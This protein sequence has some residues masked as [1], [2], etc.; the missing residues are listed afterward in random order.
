MSMKRLGPLV[1]FALCLVGQGGAFAATYQVLPSNSTAQPGDDLDLSV[2]VR[3]EQGDN[4]V[5]L[6]Y[7]S[8]AI[9]LDIFGTAGAT[10]DD[11]GQVV[12]NTMLFDLEGFNAIGA[13]SGSRYVGISGLTSR[14]FAPTFGMHVGDIVDLFTFQI[15][16]PIDAQIGSEI[17]ILPSEGFL[18][19]L[20]AT[21]TFDPVSPQLFET[22][23]IVVVPEPSTF[24]L[25]GT[26]LVGSLLRSGFKTG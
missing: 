13:A 20:A 10:G 18:Q 1:A 25:L 23:R 16:I 2:S 6:G 8:F 3:T 4:V 11:I 19:N 22:T 14:V 12:L 5:G 24:L 7:V 21:S 9:D 26:M 17:L 15:Q